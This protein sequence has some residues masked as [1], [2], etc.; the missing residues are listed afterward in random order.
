[1]QT[2]VLVDAKFK[3][4]PRK[5]IVTANRNGFL[6]ILDRT[7]G[8]FLFAKQFAKLQNGLRAST[9]MGGPSPPA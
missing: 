4:E 9:K 5:L 1:M 7:N 8:K 2:P 3:G 6:Y